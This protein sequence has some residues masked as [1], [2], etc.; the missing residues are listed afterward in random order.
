MLGCRRR[1][2]RSPRRFSEQEPKI[3][4]RAGIVRAAADAKVDHNDFERG[5]ILGQIAE[6]L[7]AHPK[8]GKRITFKGGAIARLVDGSNRLSKDLDSTI[9]RV[10]HRI[11]Q[12]P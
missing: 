8:I 3:T 2:G 9:V 10:G 12:T 1:A 6:L 4:F 5:Q 7:I 11:A